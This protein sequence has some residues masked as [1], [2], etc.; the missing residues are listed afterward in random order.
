M[1][2]LFLL[3]A[4][5]QKYGSIKNK[6]AA[7]HA[8]GRD[9]YPKSLK[10]AI[11]Y[12]DTHATHSVYKE[13]KKQQRKDTS[14]TDG[15]FKSETS[16]AQK[17]ESIQ[18]YCCGDKTHKSPNCPLK[19]KVKKNDWFKKTAVIPK[20]VKKNFSQAKER[21]EEDESEDDDNSTV[22]SVASSRSTSSRKGGKWDTFTVVGNAKH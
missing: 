9:E 17:S 5:W 16:F 22:T 20:L 3:N 12:L 15:K 13:Y 7:S 18:C 6:L 4:D 19:D 8:R 14:G 11:Y 2:L 21:G 1:G 10:S